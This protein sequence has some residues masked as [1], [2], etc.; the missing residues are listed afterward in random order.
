MEMVDKKVGGGTGRT[1]PPHPESQ[2]VF[3]GPR[4]S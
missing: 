4:A 2:R 3:P 1:D